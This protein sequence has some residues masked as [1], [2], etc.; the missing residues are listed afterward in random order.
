MWGFSN[1]TDSSMQAELQVVADPVISF[2]MLAKNMGPECNFQGG[3]VV[4]VSLLPSLKNG[5]SH[6]TYSVGLLWAYK[7]KKYFKQFPANGI[8]QQFTRTAL[9]SLRASVLWS[10]QYSECRSYTQWILNLETAA[11]TQSP[12]R[13][14]KGAR[15]HFREAGGKVRFCLCLYGSL[16]NPALSTPLLILNV[17]AKNTHSGVELPGFKSFLSLYREANHILGQLKD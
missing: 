3:N 1:H 12:C 7:N 16:F 6:S 11:E 14:E 15:F 9:T 2:S 8:Y 10:T 17:T 5:D 13:K 4:S